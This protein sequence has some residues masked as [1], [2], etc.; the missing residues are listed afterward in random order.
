MYNLE[1]ARRKINTLANRWLD[2]R[3][4]KG[5]TVNDELL[6]YYQNPILVVEHD[7]PIGGVY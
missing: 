5:D 1:V 4:V 6:C 7:M 2:F 3:R